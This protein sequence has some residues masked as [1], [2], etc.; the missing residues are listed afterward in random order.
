MIT[1]PALGEVIG[2]YTLG[3]V[4]AAYLATARL[5]SG[6]DFFFPFYIIE[7]GAQNLH[8]SRTVLM[9]RLFALAR[10]LNPL[11]YE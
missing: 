6:F 3:T 11:E 5:G 1:N 10:Q 7:F 4:A 8:G 9:L 2:S